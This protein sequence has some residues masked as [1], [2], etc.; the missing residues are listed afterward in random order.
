[1]KRLF[2]WLA[3]AAAVQAHAQQALLPD[4]DAKV[5]GMGGVAMTTLGGSHAIY[6]NLATAAFAAMPSQAS[7][8]YY[9][10]QGRG[11]YALSGYARF[12]FANVV[13]GAWRQFR[14]AGGVG[15][16]MALD[17]GYA[18][19]IDERWGVGITGR[20]LRLDRPGKSGLS[21]DA[22][23]VDL[24]AAYMLPVE[25]GSYSTLRFGAKL[26]NL[27]G[28]L[29][30]DTRSMPVDLTVGAALD[31]FVSDGHEIT[32]G[33]DGGYLFLPDDCRGVRLSVGV[34]Y[35]LMQLLQVRAGYHFEERRVW[36]PSHWSVGMGARFLH[37]RL[38]FA[39]LIADER[40]PV[41]NSY[42]ISFG[43]DF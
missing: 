27:G 36:S 10:R 14:G 40:E 32:F 20:Y 26:G 35:N 2:V 5:M 21:A 11:G 18:R 38:D 19:R 30:G 39:Y 29:H 22:L 43:F 4:P 13:Q 7:A 9:D 41:S 25:M 6:G 24:G 33:V 3:A 8:S 12:G 17:L 28:W 42:S 15:S 23:A 34:E 16:D 37:L 31:S 1:M